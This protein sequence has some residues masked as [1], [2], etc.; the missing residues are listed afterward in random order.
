M[1]KTIAKIAIINNKKIAMI[2]KIKTDINLLSI[3]LKNVMNVMKKNI[4]DTNV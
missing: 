1:T 4:N 3:Y 2:K